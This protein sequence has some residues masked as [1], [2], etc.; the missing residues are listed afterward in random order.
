MSSIRLTETGSNP[1]DSPDGT[2]QLYAKTDGKLYVKRGE[3]S[4]V[5]ITDS[6]TPAS[7]GKT[8]QVKQTVLDKHIAHS[9]GITSYT[10]VDTDYRLLI[11]P[12]STSNKIL[13]FYEINFSVANGTTVDFK[14][15]RIISGTTDTD[16]NVGS[17]TDAPRTPTGVASFRGSQAHS[18]GEWTEM[19]THAFLDSPNTTSEITYLCHFIPYDS[20]RTVH[21]NNTV[22]DSGQYDDIIVTSTITAIEV[23]G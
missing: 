20:T 5:S 13:L 23:A 7:T 15:G 18:T 6:S 11:T 9:S 8:L 21:F 17:T 2:T 4:A 12:A 1:T 10:E 16:I 14:I 3:N 22:A 19:C